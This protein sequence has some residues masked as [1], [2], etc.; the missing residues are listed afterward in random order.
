M[1]ILRVF[2]I[3]LMASFILAPQGTFGG[4]PS[5]D[6]LPGYNERPDVR[7]GN[8]H[9]ALHNYNP[10]FVLPTE[11]PLNYYS[12]IDMKKWYPKSITQINGWVRLWLIVKI[13][14]KNPNYFSDILIFVTDDRTGKKY[15]KA[16]I[17]ATQHR[18]RIG[19]QG[20]E[21]TIFCAH[22]KSY[23]DSTKEETPDWRIIETEDS[24]TCQDAVEQIIE[25]VVRNAGDKK[26]L[27]QN[28]HD[29]RAV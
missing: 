27:T 24:Y 15:G 13:D 7:P 10:Y 29:L 8:H 18:K 19:I 26:W 6:Q 9:P 5:S 12:K 22:D 11:V 16:R 1:R 25:S 21:E 2:I 20:D 28:I 4:I 3:V 17:I 23:L 14:T